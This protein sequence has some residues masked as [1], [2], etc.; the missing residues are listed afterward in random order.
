LENSINSNTLHFLTNL[1]S[2]ELSPLSNHFRLC[3]KYRTMVFNAT[4]NNISAISWQL[5]LFWWRKQE[6]LEKTTNLWQATDKQLYQVHLAMNGIHTHNFSGDRHWLHM[7]VVN[8]TTIRS[9]SS[10][11]WPNIIYFDFPIVSTR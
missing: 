7:V 6:Y 5:A 10:I 3:I 1:E 2:I 8:P 4:F 9:W 11:Y